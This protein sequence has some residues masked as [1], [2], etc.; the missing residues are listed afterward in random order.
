[1]TIQK[2]QLDR[3]PIRM[4]LA[5]GLGQAEPILGALRGK[6]L[7]HLVTDSITASQVLKLDDA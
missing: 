7:T 5:W 1:V 4:G 2:E 3:L 6:F